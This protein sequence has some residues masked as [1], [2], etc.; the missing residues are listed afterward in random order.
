[1]GDKFGLFHMDLQGILKIVQQTIKFCINLAKFF[2]VKNCYTIITF[3]NISYVLGA[4]KNKI[5]FL[6]EK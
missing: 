6:G 4:Q 5:Y 3:L 1:M 2:S